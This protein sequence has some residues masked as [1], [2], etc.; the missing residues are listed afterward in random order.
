MLNVLS[1]SEMH[2]CVHVSVISV[3]IYA[4]RP[5][6]FIIFSGKLTKLVCALFILIRCGASVFFLVQH[7]G[8]MFI[9][10]NTLYVI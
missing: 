1:I 8:L 5:I 7:F 2:V 10:L 4:S 3:W 6:S 9:F